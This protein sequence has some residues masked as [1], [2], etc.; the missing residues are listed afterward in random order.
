[1]YSY[2]YKHAY[3]H[4]HISTYLYLYIYLPIYLPTYLPTYI[5]P[6]IY[7]YRWA[8]CGMDRHVVL[9][10]EDGLLGLLPCLGLSTCNR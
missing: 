1:M 6:S 7:V 8:P 5:D 10:H 9:E 2:I 3:K 4:T